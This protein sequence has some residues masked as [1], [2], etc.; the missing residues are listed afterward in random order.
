MIDCGLLTS[1]GAFRPFYVPNDEVR[2]I[3]RAVGYPEEDLFRIEVPAGASRVG[4]SVGM[5]PQSV[6]ASLYTSDVLGFGTA[7]ATLKWRENNLSGYSEMPVLL[8]PPRPLF[9]VPGSTGVALVDCVDVR[10]VW[11]QYPL[12]AADIAQVS[13]ITL[14][15][16]GRF[17]ITNATN[18]SLTSLV[19]AIT[20]KMATLYGTFNTASYAPSSVLVSR[21]ADMVFTP[22]TSLALALD[23]ILALTGYQLQ[24]DFS[25][26]QWKIV[27]IGNDRSILGSWMTTNKIASAGGGQATSTTGTPIEPLMALWDSDQNYQANAMPASVQV[28]FPYRNVE[29]LT[30]YNLTTN[31]A[32]QATAQPLL[33]SSQQQSYY[34]S[35]IVTARARIDGIVRTLH[36]TRPVVSGTAPNTDFLAANSTQVASPGWDYIQYSDAVAALLA[37]RTSVMTGRIM[38]GGWATPPNGSFRTNLRYGLVTRNGDLVPVTMTWCDTD[39]WL[40]GPSGMLP[41]EPKDIING[42]GLTSARRLALGQ[43][44]IDSAAPQTR[45]FAARIT[46][47]EQWAANKW[48]YSFEEVDPNFVITAGAWILPV[49]YPRKKTDFVAKNLCEYGNNLVTGV[50]APG[51]DPANYPNATVAALPISNDTVVT[52]VEYWSTQNPNT[53]DTTNPP[54]YWFSMP[55]AVDVDCIEQ[56]IEPI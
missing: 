15:A 17:V 48:T 32:N 29:G 21:L 53:V 31:A 49:P 20:T 23:M 25:T 26:N 11:S 37:A 18:T 28:T 1:G 38:W 24:Y 50:I 52:M 16:D 45:V 13:G 41:T 10:Y 12:E 33:F 54:Q 55:N 4:R 14:S 30:R 27:V 19:N 43:L 36:E 6:L 8:L 35:N 51:V 44:H 2:D 3:C 22:N 34:L 7:S 47:H 39:D 46:G 42:K 56:I 40:I 9:M 5:I